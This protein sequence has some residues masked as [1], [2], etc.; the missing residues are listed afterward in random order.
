MDKRIPEEGEFVVCKISR[1]N[2]NSA[3]AYLEE[4]GMEGMIHISEIVS[5]WIRDIKNHLKDG[6][7]VIAKVV[8][9]DAAAGHINLSLKRVTEQQKK[10]KMKTYKQDQKAKKMFEM[11]A[12]QFGRSMDDAYNEAGFLMID[13]FGSLYNAFKMA[14]EKP[15][16]V[17]ERGIPRQWAAAI[18]DIAKKNIELK[19]FYF[20]ARLAVKTYKPQGIDIIKGMLKDV[21]KLGVDVSYISAPNY[22]V[23]YSTKSKKGTKEF[24]AKK[25]KIISM[26]RSIGLE[27]VIKDA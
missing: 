26:A 9:V 24:E 27:A 17:E 10:E 19:E 5:G 22:M 12:A 25:E 3:F 6:Q 16:I 7:I 18:A 13:K 1:I 14:M 4:Y 21:K 20:T 15:G 8:K 2:P 11:V 23:S